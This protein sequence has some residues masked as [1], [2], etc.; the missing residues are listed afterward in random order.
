MKIFVKFNQVINHYVYLNSNDLECKSISE[1]FEGPYIDALERRVSKIIIFMIDEELSEEVEEDS[2]I[3]ICN[4]NITHKK[5][6]YDDG[7][8]YVDYGYSYE[9]TRK[10]E[11][12][13]MRV[14]F[15]CSDLAQLDFFTECI[16]AHLFSQYGDVSEVIVSDLDD[17]DYDDY[18]YEKL[19]GV[20]IRKNRSE[21]LMKLKWGEG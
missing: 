20:I 6:I 2:L 15:S 4:V 14:N 10:I 3:N 7:V 16:R 1:L 13:I 19:R 12:D 21:K 18:N 5:R 8:E 11:F 17:V 9:K